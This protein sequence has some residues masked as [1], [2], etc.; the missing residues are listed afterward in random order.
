M[1]DSF[2]HKKSDI[3]TYRIV[4]VTLDSHNARPCERA[5]LNMVPD[6]EGLHI[7]I[8]AAA[9]W[10]EDPEAFNAV[11]ESI[12][13]ADIIVINLLFLEHHVKR[14][15]P[16]IQLRRDSCDAIV[17]MISDAELVKQTKMGALDM[18]SPQSNVMS[19][20]KKLR[21]S[22][23][24]SSESGEKKMRM[25]RRLPKIL[26]FI[27]GKSQ[28]LRAWFLAMQYWLGGTDENI[29]SMLRFL[30][31]RYSSV[32]GWRGHKIELPKEYPDVGLYHPNSD[33][34]IFTSIED[35]PKLENPAG[36]IGILLM[37][38]YV[39]SGDTAHY[40]AVIKRFTEENIQVI[41]AFSGG[42]DA[43]PAIEKYFK[44]SEKPVIGGLLS[45]TGFSLVGGPAYNDSEAA[46]SLLKEINLPF[47]SAHPLEFQ[48]LSQWSGSSG[49]LGPIE[50][51]MLVALPEL[52][53][54]INPT[55]FA[56]RH[57]NSGQQ[58][59]MAPCV[60]RINILVERCKK[61]IFLKK[62]SPRD[63]KIAIIIFGFPPNAGAA[64]T[65]AYLNVFGSLYQTMLQMKLEGY[66]IEVPSSVEE[67]RDQVLNGNSSKFGQ[68]AN[69]AFR[70][71]ADWIVKN[72]PWLEEIEDQWG[73]APG[74]V[75]SDGSSI[76]ILGKNFGNV[77][78]G[79]Q[80]S[81]GYEG[82]PMRLLFEKGFAPTHA[83]STFYQW[84]KNEYKADAVLHFGMHG[85][86]EFMPGKQ[87]GLSGKDWPDRLIGHL[88]NIYLYA[89]NN[90]SEASLAK[91]RSNAVTVT[92]L[93]PPVTAAGLYK[94]LQE[95]KDSLVRWRE[96]LEEDDARPELEVLIR[97]QAEILDF[98][99]TDIDALWLKLLETEEALVP[100]GLHVLGE[101]LSDRQCKSYVDAIDGLGLEERDRLFVALKKQSEIPALMDA[102][103]GQYIPPVPG[104][105]I[106]R[107][108][109]ILPTGRNI[110]AFDPFRMPTIFAC[111]Q[112]E[113]QAELLLKTHKKTPQTVALVLWGSDNIKS[114]GQQIAQALALIGAKPRF[115]SFGRLSG[116]D[117]IPLE[118]LGRPRI[119]VV[120]TL[121]GIFRD[122]LP[123]QTKMLAEAAYKAAMADED[124]LQ[125]FVRANVLDYM[126]KTNSDI[127]TAA[128]RI[129]SNAEGAYGS[130][131]NQ[132]VDS[133]S[134]DEEDE[135][136][137]AY[138]ARKSFAYGRDGKPSQNQKL[139]RNVL[140]KVELAYQNLESVELGITTVDHYFDTL[141]GISKAV[142]RARKG[143]K[144]DVYISDHTRGNGK[145][146]TLS[147]QVSLE[148]RSRSLNPKF[149]ESLLDHGA[150]GV[151]QLEA[152]VTNTLGW[153]AT[154]GKVE[155]WVYQRISE[156]FVLDEEMRNRISELNPTA[157][158]RM[159]NRLLEANDR[160]YWNPDPE[161]IAALQD[162]AD[163]LE[164]RMEG[165]AA[166]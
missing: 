94:G 37:R 42:L 88:P 73:A 137:D 58:R 33:G 125:N 95:L 29:E 91:R 16:E 24:P 119:D 110:H 22:S 149:Y 122:L 86:L 154:T 81:F 11:R 36:T 100:E 114:D 30:I 129:F 13:Q 84:L 159:A 54:A 26:K 45:L 27:P 41:P 111:R 103:A 72:T 23:K 68:E 75:Q 146:R 87:V 97:E 131:V 14:L 52:D 76:F 20:L 40:D 80:P 116:A 53:G 147:D 138:E 96:M 165:V 128:L 127:E 74:R 21:G 5:L 60:E 145:V 99:E 108:T 64:G 63:K 155:P 17:G 19:L 7:D 69:V 112:G 142:S 166:Q 144:I 102:L 105:D 118:K 126:A 38:S 51:T 164:D 107:S 136:A 2:D 163:T 4:I 139:L 115:D 8:F 158:S 32:E 143:Q 71:D 1:R 34:K 162:A 83:F 82:D 123:L 10:D 106:V 35:L 152:Q 98:S 47:V 65:A 28:D 161:T 55:V 117:L 124:P 134:F 109:D 12:A 148:T 6:F 157:S 113:I 44:N 9:E 59:A 132:L 57:G 89:C 15:L 90:P 130:N 93:T 62:K 104:G 153:S 140:A 78:V 39:L 92:H 77:F 70:V 150:E 160:S 133:S 25:L 120:M 46:I 151:R 49:G 156:T 66:D 67:L 43:R 101:E 85:A 141:G 79:L 56:G 61:L 18:L 3:I 121:S 48:T 135:L 31:S 50:T